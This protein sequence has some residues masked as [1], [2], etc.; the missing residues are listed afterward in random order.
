MME[1]HGELV[2]NVTIMILGFT[3]GH[4][5]EF[6]DTT[7]REFIPEDDKFYSFFTSFL[8]HFKPDP[9]ASLDV[10]SSMPPSEVESLDASRKNEVM[11]SIEPVD[12]Y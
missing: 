9:M 10:K 7:L 6:F 11:D 12:H 5:E 8:N 2:D 3:K 1:R 4:Y